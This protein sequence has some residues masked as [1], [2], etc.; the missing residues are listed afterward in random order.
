MKADKF[1]VW[2]AIVPLTMP[3]TATASACSTEDIKITQ[4]DIVRQ[5]E[6]HLTSI[7]VGEL[8]NGCDEA[9]GVNFHVTLRDNAGKVVWT[10]DPWPAGIHNIRPHATYAFTLNAEEPRPA[11]R[12]EIDVAEVHK[13]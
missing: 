8:F 7:I 2:I 3:I 10:D 13:W 5:G 6:V 4:A 12:V 11:V 9:I 1:L